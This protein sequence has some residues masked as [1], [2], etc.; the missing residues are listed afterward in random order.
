MKRFYLMR[1]EDSTGVSGTGIVA[2][3]VEWP[4]G[5]VAMRWLVGDH[6]STAIYDRIASVLA[7]HGHQG[8]TELR[9]IDA[10]AN[11]PDMKHNINGNKN[12]QGL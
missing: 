11:E 8:K 7:I 9:W 3:G 5:K 6:K 12:R 1:L 2:S 10:P 4:D